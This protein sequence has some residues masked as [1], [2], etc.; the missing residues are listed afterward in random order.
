MNP[1]IK[2]GAYGLLLAAMV[3]GGAVVGAAAGPIDVGGSPA[4]GTTQAEEAVTAQ[5]PAGGLLV[6]QDGYTFEP[7]DR[8]VDAGRFAFTITG[9]HG[10]PV[11]SYE[12][13]N[14]RELHLVVASR[15]L[16]SYVHL[17]PERDAEGGWTVDLPELPPGPYRAF[18][19][20]QPSGADQYTL[21]VD[22]IAPGTT[23]A[24]APLTPRSSDTVDAYEVTL[25]RAGT[26]SSTE[27]TVTVR[28]DGDVV[29]TD[30][31]LGAPGQLVALRQ[32]DLAYLPVRPLDGEASGPVSFAVEVPTAGTY[33]LFFDFQVDGVV[34]TAT[35][36]V[37]IPAQPTDPAAASSAGGH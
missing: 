25:D 21:G 23:E 10:G 13:L 1:G 26:G 8:L 15:D 30:P 4:H 5:L 29:R 3:G 34:R 7:E 28:R 35:F 18:A 27:M 36:V 37:D 9:P 2:L 22:L 12:L 14:D 31:Y 33:A 20:F 32:G 11:E 16:Q 24:P 6:A 19:D 17:H